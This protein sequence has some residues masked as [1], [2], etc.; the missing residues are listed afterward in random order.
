MTRTEKLV[1]A[2]SLLV[3]LVAA[4]ATASMISD[5]EVELD[6][7][8]EL[9]LDR[10]GRVLNG[11]T[12]L[13]SVVVHMEEELATFEPEVLVLG[14]SYAHT[15]VNPTQLARGLGID[16]TEVVVFSVPNSVSSHWYAILKNR[17]YARGHRP[18]LVLVVGSLR[19]LLVYEPYSDAAVRNLAIQLEP[20]EPVLDRFLPRSYGFWADVDRNRPLL[21]DH[22]LALLRD[23]SVGLFVDDGE[24]AHA[25][26][27]AL[28]RVFHDSNLDHGRHRS[29][30]PVLEVRGGLGTGVSIPI[31]PPEASLIPELLDL[32][33]RYGT[34]VAFVRTPMAPRTPLTR[35]DTVP[36]GSEVEVAVQFE[37]RGNL[38]LDLSEEPMSGALFQDL[39]HLTPAGARKLTRVMLEELAPFAADRGVGA[40]RR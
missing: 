36:E 19:G 34:A 1:A 23:R 3:P 20:E 13:Q 39:K 22:T 31:P 16:P 18:R 35:R 17:V 24:D 28:G 37:A 14:A 27:Q 2:L 11:E 7:K 9:E 4:A 8:E 5:F 6:K 29:A 38:F 32:T 40:D 10:A 33:G 30:L 25:T 21:R 12:L 15:N 26:E